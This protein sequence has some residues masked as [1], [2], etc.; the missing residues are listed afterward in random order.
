M[1]WARC[2]SSIRCRLAVNPFTN[3][4]WEQIILQ[5]SIHILLLLFVDGGHFSTLI[6]MPDLLPHN[7]SE[8]RNCAIDTSSEFKPLHE[9]AKIRSSVFAAECL[10]NTNV[11][12]A[13]IQLPIHESN[14]YAPMQDGTVR[15]CEQVACSLRTNCI[16]A[17]NS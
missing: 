17:H 13:Q 15:L 9:S 11:K 14:N 6:V 1:L 10:T 3:F 5:R 4:L 8:I 7:V 2:L 16:I 12:W